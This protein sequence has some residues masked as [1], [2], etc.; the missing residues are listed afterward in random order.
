[1]TLAQWNVSSDGEPP[2]AGRVGPDGDGGITAFVGRGVGR[3]VGGDVMVNAEG[4]KCSKT[5]LIRVIH[6]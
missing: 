3:G 1:M 4:L 5:D 6:A 2:P